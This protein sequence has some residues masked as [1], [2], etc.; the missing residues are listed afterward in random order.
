M[1]EQEFR[2]HVAGIARSLEQLV[3]VQR[4]LLNIARGQTIQIYSPLDV[5]TIDEVDALQDILDEQACRICGCTEYTPC[6]DPNGA[7]PG[8][9]AP[10]HWIGKDLC[11]VCATACARCAHED[12][13]NDKPIKCEKF[14]D[15]AET[16]R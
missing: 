4:Q 5:P 9:P 11:S 12:A 2:D 15:I 13:C 6:T 10:C 8:A 1:S 14:L 3:E 7:G 16:M